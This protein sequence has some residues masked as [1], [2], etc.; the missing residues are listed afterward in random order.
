MSLKSPVLNIDKATFEEII[1][2][3]QLIY[4][5]ERVVY[6]AGID[7]SE[8]TDH[9]HVVISKLF[10]CVFTQKQVD[11]IFWYLLERDPKKGLIATQT[12]AGVKSE[13]CFDNDSLWKELQELEIKGI[14]E[15]VVKDHMDREYYREMGLRGE[16]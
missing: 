5:K 14:A 16:I 11:L 7:I 2:K 6:S 15:N 12:I 1:L 10:D 3:L 4:R 13:I 9:F 8:L